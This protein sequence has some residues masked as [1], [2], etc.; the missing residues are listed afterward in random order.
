MQDR[1]TALTAEL[2]H[3]ASE[4]TEAFIVAVGQGGEALGAVS[5]LTVWIATGNA[6]CMQGPENPSD[7]L[8]AVRTAHGRPFLRK[9][10]E[11][12]LRGPSA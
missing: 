8:I 7:G 11:L 10:L 6:L 12:V 9:V 3:R 2:K 4:G 1:L 5:G